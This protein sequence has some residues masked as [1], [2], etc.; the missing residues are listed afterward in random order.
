MKKRMKILILASLVLC[1]MISQTVFAEMPVFTVVIGDKS[2]S[3]GYVNNHI[4]SEEINKLKNLGQKIYVK[5]LDGKWI[6]N[7]TGET[8]NADII[9]EVTYKD[10][11][12]KVTKYS[13]ND[14]KEI[15]ENNLEDVLLWIKI[16]ETDSGIGQAIEIELSDIGRKKIGYVDEYQIINNSGQLICKTNFYDL[17]EEAYIYPMQNLGDSISIRLF[18]YNDKEMVTFQDIK[19]Q[20]NVPIAVTGNQIK[21]GKV[22]N[23]RNTEEL[24]KNIGSNKTIILEKGEYDLLSVKDIENPH[25]DYAAVNDGGELI[26]DNIYNLTI[27]GEN[28]EDVKLLVD[29][30][31]ANVLT[32][33]DSYKI[34]ISDV[35]AGHYPKEDYCR[36]G[37]FR[38]EYCRDVNINNCV[39]YG[40]GKEGVNLDFVEDF[41]FNNS[42]IKECSNGIMT[43]INSD[44]IKFV[45]SNFYDNEDQYMINIWNCDNI[46]FDKC[47]IH[48]NKVNSD[49]DYMFN[50]HDSSNINV[51]DCI[52][53]NNKV[54]ELNN[55]KENITFDNV[56]Y[57]GDSFSKDDKDDDTN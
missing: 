2:F 15:I 21:P 40:C 45:N 54:K 32:F 41:I 46:Q 8:V 33:E 16:S 36:N 19:V 24:L 44:N 27:K 53:K 14:G 18:D 56:D 37:V 7:I 10:E 35:T 17:Y 23:V 11:H 28:A 39:L 20:F 22:I 31:Y 43:L 42:V 3:L 30:R 47:N 12:G 5:S 29:P 55:C 38:F 25:I 4:H 51:K 26:I 50:M 9:P 48:D 49:C 6:D 34:N 1:F 52:I 57:D 13:R